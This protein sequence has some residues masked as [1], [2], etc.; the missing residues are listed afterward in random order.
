MDQTKKP[1][2]TDSLSTNTYLNE[3]FFQNFHKFRIEW[4]PP[5][6]SGYGGYI[7]WFLDGKLVTAVFGDDLQ[8]TSQTE[9]PSEPMY[10]VMNVAVSKDWGFPDAYFKNCPKKCWSCLDPGCACALP[11][12]FCDAIPTSMEIDSVRV[13][14]PT[15]GRRYSLGCSPPDRP[16][17]AFIESQ[18][19]AYK[20]QNEEDPLKDIAIGGGGCNTDDDCGTDKRGF[21]SFNSTCACTANWTGPNCLSPGGFDDWK[22]PYFEQSGLEWTFL[23]AFLVGVVIVFQWKPLAWDK[24]EKQTYRILA[25]MSTSPGDLETQRNSP[26]PFDSYQRGCVPKDSNHTTGRRW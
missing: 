13:Y 24:S 2:R 4:E 15:N 16:T 23:L 18:K 7:K 22:D 12:G 3:D 17:K 21:C 8:A 9:I 1:Y 14:Q 6:E 26:L 19:D 11:K 25:T 10:L 5:E 20:L